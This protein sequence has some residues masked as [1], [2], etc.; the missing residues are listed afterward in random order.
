MTAETLQLQALAPATQDLLPQLARRG[1]APETYLAGSAALALHLAHRPVRDLDLMAATNRLAGPERRDLLADLAVLDPAV[2][3]ET[4]R[5]GYLFARLGTGVGV[6][7]FH[8]PYP[9]VDAESE[10]CGLAV[11]SLPDLGLMKLAAVISRGERRDFGDLFLLCR[12]LPLAALLARAPEKFGHVGDFELQ[13]LKAL[14]DRGA[15]AAEPAPRLTQPLAWEEVEEWLR[16]EVRRLGRAHL[17]LD[18]S[19]AGPAGP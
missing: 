13:A 17:G 9:L 16:A 1:W 10:V 4:A 12:R 5:D 19:P 6:K 11:A 8:Y 14:A 3:V 7:L 18:G 15:A 2:R